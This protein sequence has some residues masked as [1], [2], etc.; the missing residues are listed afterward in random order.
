MSRLVVRRPALAILGAFVFLG[1][2][3][4]EPEPSFEKQVAPLL[5]SR[6]LK[7]HNPAK[8]RGE[9]DLTTRTTLLKGGEAGV[10]VAP[11]K[12]AD[13]LLF[14][15]VRDGKMPPGQPLAETEVE[16][17]RRWIDAGAAW[18]EGL[19]LKPARRKRVAPDPTG[20]RCN[21]SAGPPSRPSRIADWVRNPIDAF[22]LA[23]LEAKGLAPAPEADRRTLIRRVTFDLTGLPPTPE[24]IDAF[25]K[26]ESRRRL[27]EGGGPAAGPAGIRRTLGPPLARR[28]ALRREP[29]LRDEHAAAQRL[30]LPRLRH[31]GVQRRHSLSPFR[32]RAAGR[33]RGGQATR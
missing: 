9:L 11:G 30:A 31:P 6:C 33:R 20:G 17:L 27:R 32:A 23:G 2:A 12:S 19:A 16:L 7:C 10:V 21:R 3:A 14:A 22:I 28:G 13:S 8:V 18:Q 1:A 29:R 24:E 26:D 4:A 5:Q 25:L 15:K